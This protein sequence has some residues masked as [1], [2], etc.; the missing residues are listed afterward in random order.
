M[1]EGMDNNTQATMT[2]EQ[3]ETTEQ[4]WTFVGHWEGDRI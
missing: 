3:T 4:T 2:S 1:V